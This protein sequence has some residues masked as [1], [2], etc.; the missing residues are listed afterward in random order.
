[1]ERF[2]IDYSGKNIPLPSAND[3][4]KRLIEA[5]EKV[6]KTMR[7]K[8]F[9]YLK[10][11]NDSS[12]SS[13][14]EDTQTNN[15][16]GLKSKRSPPFIKEMADFERDM[17]SIVENVEFRRTNNPLMEKMKE[18]V[19]R[20]KK[21]PKVIVDADKT[22]NRYCMKV[23]DYE[24][25]LKENITQKY[26]QVCGSVIND[27][28]KEFK[29]V[30]TELNIEDRISGQSKNKAFIT[31][32][33]HKENFEARTK[34]R[35]INPAKSEMG[36]VS[37]H[38]LD[39]INKKIR[40]KTKVQQWT[41]TSSVVKWFNNIKSKKKTKFI[42]FDIVDFYPS[43]SENLLDKCLLWAQKYI[44]IEKEEMHAIKHSRRTLLYDN[45]GT[46]WAKQ[47]A[48]DQ[49][50]VSMGA[51]DGA[52]ICELVG[53]YLLNDIE[54]KIKIR[55]I[56]LYRDDGLAAVTACP[57]TKME[58]IRKDLVK[59]FK[60]NGLRITADT[61]LTSVNFLDVNFDLKTELHQPYKKP[62]DTTV[63]VHVQSNHP[64]TIIKNIPAAVTKRLSNISSNQWTFDKN[65]SHYKKALMEAGYV[66]NLRYSPQESSAVQK[67]PRQRNQR[68]IIWFNPPF[69]MN[70]KTNIGKK[71]LALIKKHFDNK[72]LKKIF[73][74]NT[75]KISY[76]CMP[77]INNVITSHNRK[78]INQKNQTEEKKSCNCR[79]KSQ[80]PMD[81]KCLVEDI[82]YKAKVET[83]HV[84]AAYIGIASGQFKTRF[85][86]H[87]KSFRNKKYEKE[88]ELSKYIWSLKRSNTN[89]QIKWSISKRSNTIKRR[90]GTCN[91][92][93][94]EKVEIMRQ[95]TVVSEKSLNKRSELISTCR[96]GGKIEHQ[97][98]LTT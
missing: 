33:D 52:E 57:G 73:N 67:K 72:K 2:N 87:T 53:L 11:E 1:M 14:N 63:Y 40:E 95:R 93:L 22:R 9:F 86:N 15:N 79:Q 30:A 56:G 6:I 21:C 34:C 61:N 5:T 51:Y 23:D 36:K 3:Y 29:E 25:L 24:K 32:K 26:K 17:L 10:N 7:W 28:Q 76:S 92:C 89:Y 55:N 37:K 64:P 65:I 20:I 50:D 77:N 45:E 42:T 35:L 41:S 69:S 66:D 19:N 47:D 97:P 27:I 94:D 70:V 98:S 62:N 84:S 54:K 48:K 68:K 38:I 39:K 80:C 16:F 58:K 74:K 71:F 88:T 82:V 4:R 60:D 31:I 13:D 81:G 59:L 43:I 46:A 44:K 85:N 12:E 96:H 90:S 75:V 18:D 83:Q 91:L 49:F 8:A 78:I